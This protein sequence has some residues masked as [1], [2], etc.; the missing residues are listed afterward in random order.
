[1]S[2]QGRPKVAIERCAVDASDDAVYAAVSRAV[3]LIGGVPD[4]VRTAKAILIKPNYV[5]VIFKSADHEVRLT[6]GGRQA[7][8][9]EPAVTEA[10]VRLVREANP[11]ATIWL[12][13]GM[14]L[15]NH[16]PGE[17]QA[18]GGAA[19][20]APHQISGQ[21]GGPRTSADVFRFMRAAHL[22]EKYGVR[23]VD[24]NAGEDADFV[25]VPVPGGG[26]INKTLRVRREVAEADTVV[27]VAKLKCHQ[28]AGVTLTTK[29]LFGLL[30]RRFHGSRNRGFMHQNAFR[31]MR[32]FV[33]V[34]TA[35]RQGLSVLDG[36][37]GT[38]GGMNGDPLE[39][40]CVLAGTNHVATDAVAMR[41][42]GFDP[43]ADFPQAPFLISENHIRLAERR[44]LGTTDPSQIELLGE[45]PEAFGAR[46]ETRPDQGFSPEIAGQIIRAAREQA[47]AYLQKESE[48]VREHRGRFVY[49]VDGRVVASAAT[50]ADAANLR[51]EWQR[52][53]GY[54]LAVWAVPS[55]EQRE[56][57]ETYVSG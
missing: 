4:V 32:T 47:A 56:R 20:P 40:G 51:P 27:S 28:T 52:D 50:I 38:T 1:M 53:H 15:P 55:E 42:M 16:V 33:D 29:N 18:L 3:E 23:L 41:L 34:N 31:L 25:E 17:S 35:F 30:P 36:L 44:G 12:G 43:A 21:G 6:A 48:I 8:N 24:F 39:V 57:L 49:V 9:T 5:G 13:E 54:G 14:D 37:V 46:F 19:A 45:R 7:H 22:P 26:L 11:G 10:V 2:D